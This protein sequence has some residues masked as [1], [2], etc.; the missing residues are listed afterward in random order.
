VATKRGKSSTSKKPRQIPRK[1]TATAGPGRVTSSRTTADARRAVQKAAAAKPAPPARAAAK[2]P[3][4]PAA[5]SRPA[6]GR[7]K[8]PAVKPPAPAAGP[9][10][11][12]GATVPSL[13][14][15]AE[16]LRDDVNRSKLTHPDP[17][18]FAAKARAWAQRAQALV[19]Q[20][21]AGGDTAESRRAVEALA[22][23]VERDRDF[24]EARKLF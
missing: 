14:E 15:Q 18:A 5:A 1:P 19:E 11:G 17:W 2:A 6:V 7:V 4:P 10:P 24:Q 13:L 20:V 22:A 3:A 8:P 21:A 23:E 9:R 12:G 16:R